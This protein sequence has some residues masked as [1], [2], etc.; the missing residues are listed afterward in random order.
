MTTDFAFIS[1]TVRQVVY[2]QSYDPR[3]QIEGVKVIPI[4][5][6]PAEEGDFGEILRLSENGEVQDVPGFHVRQ[7]NRSRLFPGAIKA[8]HV[9]EFQDEI[10]YVPPTFS[11]IV[12]LWD[13]RNGS[14]SENVQTKVVLGGNVSKV[15]FI[16]HGVAHGMANLSAQE[17]EMFYFMNQQFNAAQP[18]EHRIP[19]NHLGDA[20]WTPERD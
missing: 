6:F 9:H 20:F 16:P 14:P 2:T 8:W 18:D 1:P 12:G 15:V 17:V 13:V 11:L 7:I 5:S 10:W 19:W 4:K 3:P